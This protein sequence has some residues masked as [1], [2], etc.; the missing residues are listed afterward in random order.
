MSGPIRASAPGSCKPDAARVVRSVFFV[1]R[2]ELPGER[3]GGLHSSDKVVRTLTLFSSG[4]GE[5]R[6]M[7]VSVS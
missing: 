1:H 3:P 6:E 2:Q 4:P 7:S 5:S